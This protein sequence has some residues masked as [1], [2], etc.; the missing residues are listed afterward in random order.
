MEQQKNETA[1]KAY[2]LMKAMPVLASLDT[3][4]TVAFYEGRLGFTHSYLDTNYAIVH[5]DGICIHFWKCTDKVFPE[6]T[7]CYVD[8]VGI[9]GLY[10][11]MKAA[12]VV[13]PN[14]SLTDQPWGMRKFAILDEDG[15]MIKFGEPL[16]KQ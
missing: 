9:E 1:Q 3:A 8:A 13:H 11:E 10:A 7:S 12:G 2:Q 5:R 4:K 15:N 6:N 14:G 16:K